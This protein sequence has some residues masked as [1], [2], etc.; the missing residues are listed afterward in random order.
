M[1]FRT[2][3][4]GR[5]LRIAENWRAW[6]ARYG[7]A[8]VWGIV[9]SYLGYFAVF[10]LTGSPVTAAFGASFGE[11][12]GY[13]GCIFWREFATRM[14]AGQP[15]NAAMASAVSRDLLYEFGIPELLDS[16]V[17]RPA[18]TFLAAHMFGA[19]IGVIV[20]KIASDVVFYVLAVTLYERRKAK[21]DEA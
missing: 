6:I 13:Y 21:A 10:H 2:T 14:R 1:G 8:E 4:R 19:S 18:T 16:F 17:V 12:V 9:T 5:M 20:A 3:F 7:W 11:N 15:L